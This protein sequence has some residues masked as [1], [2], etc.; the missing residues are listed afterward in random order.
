MT[1]LCGNSILKEKEGF[2]KKKEEEYE[3]CI[4][5][6]TDIVISDSCFCTA[7]E[8]F[9]EN[10][11]KE[12]KT[13]ASILSEEKAEVPPEQKKTPPKEGSIP[14]KI[15]TVDAN[16]KEIFAENYR[17]GYAGQCTWYARGRFREVN[18]V[19]LPTIG[20]AKDWLM[21]PLVSDKVDV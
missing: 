18:G 12:E 5:A 6:V 16:G 14:A 9:K 15:E 17:I 7:P 19:E 20:Y 11:L 4:F 2:Q 13:E 10:Y 1:E 3:T 21:A 8:W